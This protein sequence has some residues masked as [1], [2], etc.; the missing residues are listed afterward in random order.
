MEIIL[1]A[2]NELQGIQYLATVTE[3]GGKVY[4][5]FVKSPTKASLKIYTPAMAQFQTC[6]ASV[7]SHDRS[8]HAFLWCTNNALQS[9]SGSSRHEWWVEA[10]FLEASSTSFTVVQ[11][12]TTDEASLRSIQQSFRLT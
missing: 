12:F 1:K 5:F 2:S 4:A 11:N 3:R 9:T 8:E 6:V 7:T 10:R